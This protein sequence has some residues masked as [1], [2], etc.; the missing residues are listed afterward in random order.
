[1]APTLSVEQVNSLVGSIVAL[2]KMRSRHAAGE[3]LNGE[4]MAKYAAVKINI[5]A[6]RKM[7]Q[8]DFMSEA[9]FIESW[10]AI[11]GIEDIPVVVPLP[12]VERPFKFDKL[13]ESPPSNESF[14]ALRLEDTES[15]I[16]Y[17]ETI[18]PGYANHY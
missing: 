16:S 5:R 9:E 6:M 18:I 4:D 13:V 15:K 17:L 10:S 8:Q 14:Y 7:L 12:V 3:R 1:M 11:A 2:N